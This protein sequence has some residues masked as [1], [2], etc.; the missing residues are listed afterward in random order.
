[1]T[2]HVTSSFCCRNVAAT[3]AAAA[4]VEKEERTLVEAVQLAIVGKEEEEREVERK[5]V[6]A[7]VAEQL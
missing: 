5:Q 2:R 4:T 7:E 6:E 3:A 1:M